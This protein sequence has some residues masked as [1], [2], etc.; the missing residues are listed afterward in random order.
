MDRP[1][2]LAGVLCGLLFLAAA[3]TAIAQQPARATSPPAV[4]SPQA[5]SEQAAAAGES[6]QQ[7]ATPEQATPN[8][9]GTDQAA[10]DQSESD[11]DTPPGD[12]AAEPKPEQ[13]EPQ[14]EAEQSDEEAPEAEPSQ[15]DGQQ[16]EV[17][18]QKLAE[19]Q[20]VEWN[21]EVREVLE[22]KFPETTSDLRVIQKQTQGVIK[23]VGPAVVSVRVG[24]AFG[25]AVIVSEDGLVLTA[26]HVV[27]RPGQDVLFLFSDGKTAKG[28]TLGMFRE[29][30]SGMMKITDPGP[31]PH[32]DM[33]ESG[34][35][36]TGEWVVVMSHP[37]GF[38]SERTPPVRL[39]RVLFAN[40]EV[41]STDCTLVGGDSGGPLFNMRG[42]VVGIN[43]RIGR[44]ITDNFHVPIC[45]YRNTWDRLLAGESWGAPL[46]GSRET[47]SRPLLGVTGNPNE[48]EC[49]LSQVFPGMPA[50]RAGLKPGDVVRSFNGEQ[51][52]NFDDLIEQVY[53]TGPGVTIKLVVERGEDKVDFELRLGEVREPIPGSPDLP[54]KSSERKEPS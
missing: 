51:I 50:A 40:D 2:R 11:G 43:S 7:D 19:Q 26:G 54:G 30:D 10:P 23:H 37:G 53:N 15:Q 29:I 42:Q 39:G 6:Q 20:P 33:A 31:W 13:T 41:I 46:G 5:S 9:D 27:G 25:S 28:K 38:D 1:Y 4:E 47:D 24:Q 44:R 3:A 52:R 34:D 12:D 45:T 8:E 35:L 22:K 49:R 16:S 21:D 48:P 32:V 18:K 14:P 17:A 36:D